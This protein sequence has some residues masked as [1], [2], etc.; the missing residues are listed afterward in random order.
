[1]EKFL[2]V[3]NIKWNDNEYVNE[4]F[5]VGPYVDET[6]CDVEEQ[7]SQQEDDCNESEDRDDLEII[8]YEYEFVL[9]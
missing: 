2:K 7:I 9:E 4:W 8:S 5:E 6:E 1:M 3:F